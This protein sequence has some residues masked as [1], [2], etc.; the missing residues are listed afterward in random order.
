[1]FHHNVNVKKQQTQKLKNINVKYRTSIQ[2]F[3][4]NNILS[5]KKIRIPLCVLFACVDAIFIFGFSM[6]RYA[7]ECQNNHF[8]VFLMFFF[9]VFFVYFL[10]WLVLNLVK[11]FYC[12]MNVEVSRQLK[13]VKKKYV[14]FVFKPTIY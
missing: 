8:S 12:E 1:M 3:F 9:F 13:N 11:I 5:L 14:N 2:C 7:G 6:C 10:C 4:Q